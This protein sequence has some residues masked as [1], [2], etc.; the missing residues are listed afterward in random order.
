[1]N[2]RGPLSGIA[3]L[4]L[5]LVVEG[6]DLQAAN[7]AAPDLVASFGVT[8]SALGPLLS[9]SLAGLFLGAVALAP[10][11]DRFGR[12]NIVIAAGLGYGAFSFA[13]A[14]SP[15]LSWLF[16]ARFAV[17][18]GLGAVLPNALV[19]AGEY[20]PARLQASAAGLAGIGITIGAALAG[21]ISA[22]ILPMYGWRSLFIV[23]GILPVF[24]AIVLIRWL[25]ESL[26]P[27]PRSSR[28]EVRMRKNPTIW[29]VIRPPMLAPTICIWVLFALVLMTVYLL[30][31]W[32]PLLL[33][34]AGLSHRHAAYLAAGYHLGGVIGAI[35]ASALLRRWRWPAVA[36]FAFLGV[37]ALAAL[38]GGV[39][40]GSF[41]ATL[42]VA[43][44]FGVTG[45]QNA[46]NGSASTSYPAAIRAAGLGWALGFGRFGSVAGPLVG[47]WAV[48]LGFAHPNQFFAVA[49]GPM[50]IA[51]LIALWLHRFSVK[52]SGSD[53]PTSEIHFS[54]R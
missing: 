49:I 6:Y 52:S 32:I 35:C 33:S 47:S 46:A 15:S 45:T 11:G 26:Q 29:H 20:A 38:A 39:G 28:E 10:L 48:S 40:T 37:A 13:C 2:P 43:A 53:S 24:V 8:R 9:A 34:D 3:L 23:G 1:M 50:A 21:L 44:G 5:A 41:L 12:K 14:A 22:Q 51:G 25:P 31:G 36:L 30:G 18:I 19:L 16:A 27:G 42:I 17:G 54:A 4:V 7:F